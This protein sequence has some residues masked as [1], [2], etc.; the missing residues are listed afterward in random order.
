M[1]KYILNISTFING[2]GKLSEMRQA[3]LFVLDSVYVG[4]YCL[5]GHFGDGEIVLFDCIDPSQLQVA[6]FCKLLD[7]F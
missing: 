6:I 3:A 1:S 4:N 7:S 2:P 5:V